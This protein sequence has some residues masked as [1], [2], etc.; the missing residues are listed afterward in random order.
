MR[1]RTTNVPE[2][3]RRRR[4]GQ[5]F[6]SC[7]EGKRTTCCGPRLGALLLL[8]RRQTESVDL[9]RCWVVPQSTLAEVHVKHDAQ[10]SAWHPF[11]SRG[12]AEHHLDRLPWASVSPS[13]QNSWSDSSRGPCCGGR[14]ASPC[15]AAALRRGALPA[16]D[17]LESLTTTIGRCGWGPRGRMV[18]CWLRRRLLKCRNPSHQRRKTTNTMGIPKERVFDRRIVISWQ[19]VRWCSFIRLLADASAFPTGPQ[20]RAP[21]PVSKK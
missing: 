15:P 6:L 4:V 3:D 13:E 19:M 1:N 9:Q 18:L 8:D 2:C 12:C 7:V 20:N 17:A 5:R 21:R 11:R 16:A 14:G 10:A